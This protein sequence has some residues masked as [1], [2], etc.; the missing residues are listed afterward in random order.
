[1]KRL[2]NT[3]QTKEQTRNTEFQI[4]EEEIDK[5]PEKQFRT[6]IVKMIRNLEN[7]MEK[8]QE[9]IN[10]HLEEL[11]NKHTERNNT[12]T[13]IKTT[14]EGINSRIPEAEERISELEYK[15][16]EITTEEQNKVKRMKR[17]EYSLRDIWDN[18]QCTYIQ[19]I[20]VPE[21]EEKKKGYEKNFEEII[22]EKFN[23][24]NMENKIVNQAQEMQRVPYRINPRRNTPRHILLKLTKTKHKER[25]LKAAREKQVTYK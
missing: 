9:S 22:V 13:E 14:L 4:N 18:I 20:R 24:P 11:K 3:T 25:I 8:M 19:I 12:I 7:K 10:K 5:L 2:R 1:M 23:F 15:M 17:T 21:D 16:V 6:R